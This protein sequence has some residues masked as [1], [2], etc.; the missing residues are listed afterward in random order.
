MY[1]HGMSSVLAHAE[2]ILLSPTELAAALEAHQQQAAVLALAVAHVQEAGRWADDGSVT[3]R[4]WM[5]DTCRMSD[6]DAGEWLRRGKLLNHFEPIAEAALDGLLS[7][8]QL[9][10]LERC[11]RPKYEALL[12]EMA[13][14]LVNEVA[15]LDAQLTAAVCQRWRERADAIIEE[16][17]PAEEPERSLSFSRAGDHAVLGRFTLDDAG[18]SEL[19]TAIRNA[20]THEGKEETRTLAQRQ[21]DAFFD[22]CAFYNKNHRA[23]G[24]KRNLPNM[25]F[26]VHADTLTGKYPEAI[27]LDEWRHMSGAYA[28]TKMCDCA[29]HKVLRDATDQPQ[30]FGRT[31][32]IVPQ[33]LFRQLVERDCGC[34]FPG[35]TRTVKHCDAHHIHYWRNMG[36]TDYWNLVLLCTRHH[37]LVHQ[38]NLQLDLQPTGELRVTWRDGRERISPPRHGPPR[39]APP[40]P[41]AVFAFA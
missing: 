11:N 7:H 15:P 37:H 6:R 40:H 30:A 35:C 22:I 23:K 31:Q 18:G 1:D 24:T 33:R 5:R 32:Y 28:D 12:R 14:G 38:Q 41:S 17:E 16:H 26:S 9:T 10:E 13:E 8:S 4:S 36:L 27:N 21:G 20:L 29:V 25:S 19:E 39:G 3:M 2:S 34:R